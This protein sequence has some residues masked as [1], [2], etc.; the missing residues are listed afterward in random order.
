MNPIDFQ[1]LI[2][3]NQANSD[4]WRRSDGAFIIKKTFFTD[5]QN[6]GEQEGAKPH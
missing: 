5:S 4:C 1:T 6:K 2:I 3:Y